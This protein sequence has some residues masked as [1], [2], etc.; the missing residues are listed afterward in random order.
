MCLV[1]NIVYDGEV[2]NLTDSKSRPY[3][4]LTS[5]PLK[6]RLGVHNQGINHRA[7]SSKCELTKH[8]WALK[9]GNKAFKVKWNIRER[10]KG[11]LIGGECRLCVT[12]KLHI[13]EHPEYGAELL[14]SNSD[15]KCMHGRKHKLF[16][17]VC[18]GRGQSK[19]KVK[20]GKRGT[21]TGV[22]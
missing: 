7:Y 6:E 5:D 13:I 2:V 22:T 3:V 14:N 12:E 19:K 21:R 10:V 18:P 17:V 20:K 4:G 11:R 8:V 9:D 1:S 16:S 15:I